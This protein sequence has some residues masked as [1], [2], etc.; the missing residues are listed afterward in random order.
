MK[1]KE[2]IRPEKAK[3]KWYDGIE[4]FDLNMKP[5]KDHEVKQLSTPYTNK[6]LLGDS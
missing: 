4:E 1:D 3:L 2:I 6:N 5:D